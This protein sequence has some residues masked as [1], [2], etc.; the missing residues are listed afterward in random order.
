MKALP[1]NVGKCLP[2]KVYY[3]GPGVKSCTKNFLKVVIKVQCCKLERLSQSATLAVVYYLRARLGA[4][5]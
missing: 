5:P 1:R 2:K 3:I 4:Y